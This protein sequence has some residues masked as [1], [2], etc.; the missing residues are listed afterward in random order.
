[1]CKGMEARNAGFAGLVLCCLT[2]IDIVCVRMV[3]DPLSAQG[4]A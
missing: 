2:F 3:N 1:M 4:I